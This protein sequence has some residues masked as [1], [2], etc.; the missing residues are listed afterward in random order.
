[1]SSSHD[2]VESTIKRAKASATYRSLDTSEARAAWLHQEHGIP[3]RRAASE[4]GLSRPS[5]QRYLLAKAENREVGKNGR[6]RL[7]SESAETQLKLKILQRSSSLD[8]MTFDEIRSEVWTSQ[9]K[10]LQ[11]NSSDAS[12]SRLLSYLVKILQ[13][14]LEHRLLQRNLPGHMYMASLSATRNFRSEKH[15]F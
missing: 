9:F 6:P 3:Q 2:S 8:S 7:L 15:V 12:Y 13:F 1:M 10:F 11:I 5:L 4:E 14:Q